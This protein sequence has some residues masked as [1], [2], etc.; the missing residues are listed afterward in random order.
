MMSC[1]LFVYKI[2]ITGPRIGPCGT[3]SFFN[4]EDVDVRIRVVFP[5]LVK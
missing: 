2:N 4:D 1:E 3:L 5:L